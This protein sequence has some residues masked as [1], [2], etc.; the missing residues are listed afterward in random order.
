MPTRDHLNVLPVEI[1]EQKVPAAAVNTLI[2]LSRVSW[3]SRKR[4]QS[5]TFAST[6]TD[7]P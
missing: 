6:K 3:T 5:R 1:S 4:R 2:D 7:G